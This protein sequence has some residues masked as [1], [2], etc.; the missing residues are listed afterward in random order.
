MIW[1][2]RFISLLLLAFACEAKLSKKKWDRVEKKLN[3]ILE[4]MVKKFQEVREEDQKDYFNNIDNAIKTCKVEIEEVFQKGSND[5]AEQ[6][7]RK[8]LNR[9]VQDGIRNIAKSISKS[10]GLGKTIKCTTL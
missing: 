5:N 8:K 2:I 3:T 10:K 1:Q 4:E 9:M 6:E 7:D